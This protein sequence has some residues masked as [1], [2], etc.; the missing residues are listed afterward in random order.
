MST[1]SED[2]NPINTYSNNN[3]SWPVG[4]PVTIMN[5]INGPGVV[6]SIQF[7]DNAHNYDATLTITIDGGSPMVVTEPIFFGFGLDP[8]NTRLSASDPPYGQNTN[9]RCGISNESY[10]LQ[11]DNSWACTKKVF[12][13][14]TTSINMYVSGASNAGGTINSQV[15]YRKWPSAFPLYYS[16]GERRK[17]WAIIQDGTRINPISLAAFDTHTTSTI[18]G[19]GQVEFIGHML[20][21]MGGYGS[22]CNVPSLL[23]G[24]YGL[25]IDGNTQVYGRSDNFWGGSYYWGST[26]IGSNIANGPDYGLSTLGVLAGNWLG[27][28]YMTGYRFF[29]DK[30]IFFDTSFTFSWTYGNTS[31][32]SFGAGISNSNNVFIVSYWLESTS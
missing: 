4:D 6:E 2:E 3:V 30:P 32:S 7:A 19:R 21:G 25:T 24:E 31:R 28:F 26:N 23:E 18:S 22:S 8:K 15:V 27:D 11:C 1:Y 10:N 5:Y 14:F 16:I 13:P 20:W 17:Y 9:I 12:I 29:Y